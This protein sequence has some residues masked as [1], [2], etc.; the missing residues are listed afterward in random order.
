MFN[1][2]LDRPGRAASRP[3]AVS[4]TAGSL[5][6]TTRRCHRPDRAAV[7]ALDG[8][9]RDESARAIGAGV[10]G[11]AMAKRRPTANIVDRLCDAVR[12]LTARRASRGA[13]PQWIMLHDVARRLEVS[14]FEI[15]Q[16]DATAV[17][18]QRLSTDCGNP[19]RSVCLSRWP[20]DPG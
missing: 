8:G 6:C 15:R 2:R 18:R 17:E 19:V 3:L 20:G 7:S 13:T 16:A 10:V 14:E 4:I 9:N 12:Q 5:T 11:W 1:V